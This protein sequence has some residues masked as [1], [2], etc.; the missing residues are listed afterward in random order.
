[1][2]WGGVAIFIGFA[3]FN[4]PP[5][6]YWNS[7]LLMIAIGVSLIAAGIGLIVFGLRTQKDNSEP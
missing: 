2:W 7:D 5:E 3:A 6:F 1:M 4:L